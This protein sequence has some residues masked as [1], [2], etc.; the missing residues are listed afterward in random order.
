[1][2]RN[3]TMITQC[4]KVNFRLS[5]T[6][7]CSYMNMF[8]WLLDFVTPL[9]NFFEVLVF[10][11]II[12]KLSLSGPSY[13]FFTL[14]SL[15]IGQ[16]TIRFLE[17]IVKYPKIAKYVLPELIVSEKMSILQKNPDFCHQ[18]YKKFIKVNCHLSS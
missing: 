5:C 14:R 17:I 8:L 7:R 15:S 4:Q 13:I 3:V 1:M 2:R 18:H 16:Y 12:I 6:E 11:Y 9:N 10:W